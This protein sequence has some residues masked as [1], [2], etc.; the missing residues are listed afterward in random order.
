MDE[1]F[2]AAVPFMAVALVIALTMGEKPL[3]G[4]DPAPSNIAEE[5]SPEQQVPVSQ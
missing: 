2:L 1:V 5:A 4:R 3:A